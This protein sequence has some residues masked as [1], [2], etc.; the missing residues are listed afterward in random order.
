MSASQSPARKKNQKGCK[1]MKYVNYASRVYAMRS[2][3]SR[4]L[5][6]LCDIRVLRST[7]DATPGDSP[8]PT[9]EVEDNHACM[10]SGCH[11]RCCSLSQPRSAAQSAATPLSKCLSLLMRSSRLSGH[12]SR[13]VKH[14]S[15]DVNNNTSAV[16]LLPSARSCPSPL[17]P[18]THE[19]I[20]FSAAASNIDH[21]VSKRLIASAKGTFG[22]A[23]EA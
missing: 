3:S 14:C 8:W 9:T 19:A 11:R 1:T 20:V 12:G 22:A 18:S 23:Y 5:F 21:A 13:A 4:K 7:A 17:S 6:T 15:S 2:T 10:R 16:G